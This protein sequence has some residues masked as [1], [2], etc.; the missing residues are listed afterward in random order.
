MHSGS[1]WA[2]AR[3]WNQSKYTSADSGESLIPSLARVSLEGVPD[4]SRW[5]LEPLQGVKLPGTSLITL[6][7]WI[8]QLWSSAWRWGSQTYR[9]LSWL[10]SD[11]LLFS[12]FLCPKCLFRPLACVLS[13][14]YENQPA[15]DWK[16][17]LEEDI[18]H[19]ELFVTVVRPWAE[20]CSNIQ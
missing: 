12:S 14:C 6:L 20:G 2:E 11:R 13:V 7:W 19:I 15:V 9:W 17:C 1:L 4:P 3:P 8:K 5:W 16:S 18:H 10:I